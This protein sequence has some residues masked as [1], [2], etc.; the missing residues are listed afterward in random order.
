MAMKDSG[1]GKLQ[2]LRRT[3][4]KSIR[5]LSRRYIWSGLFVG[6]LWA[7]A[8]PFALTMFLASFQNL[9]SQA[10]WI[11]FFPLES[12]LLLT[13]WIVDLGLVDLVS[14]TLI[15]WIVSIFLSMFL[16]VVFTYCVHRARVWRSTRRQAT[17]PKVDETAL[18]HKRS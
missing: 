8:A 18:L 3:V 4:K 2:G 11:F 6:F 1:K 15:L 17:S 16:G 14:W 13:Q 10:I 12:S 7:F 5:F 9:P